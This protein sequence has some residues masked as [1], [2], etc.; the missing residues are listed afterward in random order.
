MTP[1]KHVVLAKGID[2]WLM[3]TQTGGEWTRHGPSFW[4]SYLIRHGPG[5]L[6]LMHLAIAAT[7]S[8]NSEKR[9]AIR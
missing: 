9:K 6:V 1:Q 4:G 8:R 5:A 3:D 7:R 2:M